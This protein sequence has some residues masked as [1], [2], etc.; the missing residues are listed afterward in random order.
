MDSSSI[1]VDG[2]NLSIKFDD[3]FTTEQ[4]DKTPEATYCP[5]Q[6][7][8]GKTYIPKDDVYDKIRGLGKYKHIPIDKIVLPK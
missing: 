8:S 1:A 3:I 6:Y 7:K 2:Q 4:E 5:R